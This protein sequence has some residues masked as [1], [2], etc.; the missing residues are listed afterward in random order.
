MAHGLK[1]QNRRV[2]LSELSSIFSDGKKLK[3]GSREVLI[4]SI[5]VGDIPL[6][7]DIM[8][9]FFE[10]APK[11]K[12][13]KAQY[14]AIITK[15]VAND[16]ESVI[17]VLEVTTDLTNEEIKKLNIAAATLIV[18]EVIKDNADFF[19]GHVLPVLQGMAQSLNLAGMN[20]SKG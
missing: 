9:K 2:S 16:F 8:T 15:A 14:K 4:K 3:I 7:L 13:D 17:K 6:I 1:L 11:A 19:Q 18:A 5:A 20:K 10:V 12:A